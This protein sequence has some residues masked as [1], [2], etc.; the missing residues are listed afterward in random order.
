MQMNKFEGNSFCNTSAAK[1]FAVAVEKRVGD[2][3]EAGLVRPTHSAPA[4]K[5]ASVAA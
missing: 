4:H 5:A 1:A 2:A 3:I